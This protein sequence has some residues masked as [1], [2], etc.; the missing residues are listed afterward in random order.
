MERKYKYCSWYYWLYGA[1][2]MVLGCNGPSWQVHRQRQN[3]ISSCVADTQDTLSS[4]LRK[5]IRTKSTFNYGHWGCRFLVGFTPMMVL[6]SR[7]KFETT[8]TCVSVAQGAGVWW[9]GRLTPASPLD[10]T[11][12]PSS[13]VFSGNQ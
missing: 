10:T 13:P 11:L 3:I 4:A 8:S 5:S 1:G 9:L 12:T 2:A 7:C 6:D